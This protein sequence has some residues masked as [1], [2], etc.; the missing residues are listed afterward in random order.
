MVPENEWPEPLSEVEQGFLWF[1]SH[2]A[3]CYREEMPGSPF[4]MPS[5][6]PYTFYVSAGL[7]LLG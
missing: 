7:R 5:T 4:I 3:A 2:R 1:P 6:H